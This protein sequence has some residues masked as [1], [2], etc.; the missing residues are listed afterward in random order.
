MDRI[1]VRRTLCLRPDQPIPKPLVIPLFVVVGA[2]LLNRSPERSFSHENQMVEA[3]GFD[4]PDK[5]L[6]E[7][8]Q[9]R[10]PCR[11]AD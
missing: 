4:R 7:R 6:S 10:G 5:P 11:K 1:I 8:V 9:I 2:E 3:L